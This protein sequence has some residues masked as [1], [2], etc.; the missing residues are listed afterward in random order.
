MARPLVAIR[1][2]SLRNEVDLTGKALAEQLGWA[3]SKLSRIE[4]G[5]QRP[6]YQDI[7]DWVQICGGGSEEITDELHRLSLA[8]K[9]DATPSPPTNRL[10][11]VSISDHTMTRLVNYAIREGYTVEEAVNHLLGLANR[12]DD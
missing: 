3:P 12:S 10:L 11:G 2:R 5:K 1:L 4:L 7:R 6:S 9:P 8:D